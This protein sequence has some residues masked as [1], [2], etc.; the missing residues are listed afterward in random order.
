METLKRLLDILKFVRLFK[1]TQPDIHH[2]LRYDDEDEDE[3]KDEDEDGNI[4]N[5]RNKR[6]LCNLSSAC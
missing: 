1:S 4:Q 6:Y 5:K 2:A 3:D